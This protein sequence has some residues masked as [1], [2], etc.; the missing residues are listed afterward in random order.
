MFFKMGS[1]GKW[2][3]HTPLMLALRRQRQTDLFVFR[4]S[5]V[6]IV[7][8]KTQRNPDSKTKTKEEEEKKEEEEEEEEKKKKERNPS[9][10]I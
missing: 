9:W 10:L 4:V 2:Q 6:Y 1:R 8:S 3:W 5:L 7:G